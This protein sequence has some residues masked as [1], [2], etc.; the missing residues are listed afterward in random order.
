MAFRISRRPK[1]AIRPSTP[2][3]SESK[4]QSTTPA[5]TI[6]NTLHRPQK[7]WHTPRINDLDF[8]NVPRG[9]ASSTPQH[10][11]STPP[12]A[13]PQG[14]SSAVA[15]GRTY[16]YQRGSNKTQWEFPE[17]TQAADTLSQAKLDLQKIIDEA[18]RQQAEKLATAKAAEEERL[19]EKQREEKETLAAKEKERAERKLLREQRHQRRTSEDHHRRGSED[20]SR[21]TSDPGSSPSRSKLEKKLKTQVCSLTI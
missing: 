16:Y 13:L 4:T 12:R 14:W 1:A 18:G 15:N 17:D 10:I 2:D 9:P 19:A 7:Q 8:R 6:Q 11:L 20:H 3:D 21:R 5:R